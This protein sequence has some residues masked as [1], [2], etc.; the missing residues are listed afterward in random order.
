[1]TSII[2]ILEN[3]VK[4]GWAWVQ[5]EAVDI[6]N[7]VH[8]IVGPAIAAFEQVVI[9]DLWGA[10]VTLVQKLMGAVGAPTNLGDIETAFLNVVETLGGQLLAAAQALGSEALQSIL[11]LLQMK[12][13]PPVAA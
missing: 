4:A 8:A 11:G 2:T 7:T 12:V 9:Q 6:Y 10:G 5:K 13:K 1:M 3:D